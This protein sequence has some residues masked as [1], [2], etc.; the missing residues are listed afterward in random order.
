[1]GVKYRDC[2]ICGDVAK[3]ECTY[4]KS[5]FKHHRC[6]IC[7]D[8]EQKI[9]KIRE[10]RL[11]KKKEND[12]AKKPEINKNLLRVLVKDLPERWL[13]NIP[14]QFY[15]NE[16]YLVKDGSRKNV[17]RELL[18][19]LNE[20][21]VRKQLELKM[22]PADNRDL[23][24]QVHKRLKGK[25]DLNGD[26]LQQQI[27]FDG[28]VKSF[29]QKVKKYFKAPY[30][31][32]VQDELKIKSKA[33]TVAFTI[34]GKSYLVDSETITKRWFNNEKND[35]YE[36]INETPFGFI[37]CEKEEVLKSTM[38]KLREDGYRYGWL[39]MGTQGYASTAVI[40]I[41][42]E[43][44]KE[45][46]DKFFVFVLHD[47][48]VDGIKIYLDMKR[49]F[50]CESVGLNPHL[51]ERVGIDTNS[52]LQEYKGK[53][54]EAK[55]FQI[56]GAMSMI[57]EIFDKNLIDVKEKADLESWINACSKRRL[58]LQSLT[59]YRIEEDMTQ[60]PA[61][62]YAEYIEYLLENDE[63]IF[64]LNRFG[65]PKWGEYT[66]DDISEPN[67][68]DAK[69]SLIESMREEIINLLSNK[70]DEYL[71]E[72]DDEDFWRD[73]VS[74]VMEAA[75]KHLKAST[76]RKMKILENHKGEMVKDNEE[77]DK[78]LKKVKNYISEQSK[79]LRGIRDKKQ[80]FLRNFIN[81]INDSIELKI[82]ES[83]EY[84]EVETNLTNFKE[85]IKETLKGL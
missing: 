42:M 70:I 26:P 45:I 24:Y 76:K 54:G 22:P 53:S 17:G 6:K 36:I 7:Y 62:D 59:G 21:F 27:S 44:K 82:E 4:V 43:Y 33:R 55:L 50:H 60:N 63:R 67:I 72:Y 12:L 29:C 69:P 74:D 38:R 19:I 8:L 18:N 85:S 25:M 11:R 49:Y 28:A 47:F 1:M 32:Y 56:K 16:V 65:T 66:W 79:E 71:E 68:V 35:F 23:W 5:G 83:E 39:G 40:R 46:S 61:R 15:E 77:Y 84:N 58:E 14:E 51:L 57:Q 75:E 73:F 80:R 78:S 13:K 10:R 81:K 31:G 64:D 37:I 30:W 3:E 20:R 48:D 2:D 52:L 34:E 9:E 41:L